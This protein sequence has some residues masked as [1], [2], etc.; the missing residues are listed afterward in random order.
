LSVAV[1]ENVET[2][3]LT[4][5]VVEAPETNLE[6]EK[7]RAEKE[8]AD[9]EAMVTAAESAVRAARQEAFEARDAADAAKAEAEETASALAEGA[10]VPRRARVKTRRVDCFG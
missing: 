1:V 9:A 4:L 6:D 2:V 7:E 10:R 8:R 3:R 5:N